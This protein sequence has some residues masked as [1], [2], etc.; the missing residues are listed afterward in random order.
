MKFYINT[1][2]ITIVRKIRKIRKNKK[3]LNNNS[4]VFEI[5]YKN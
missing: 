3:K 2:F 5:D 4:K 1:K